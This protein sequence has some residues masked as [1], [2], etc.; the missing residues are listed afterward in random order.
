MGFTNVSRLAG[1]IIAYDRTLNEK[2]PE[3]ESMFRGSNFV[4]DGRL[5]RTITEDNF[6]QCV[7]CGAE[8][9]LVSNCLN[10][11]CHKRMV[12][13]EKCRTKYHGTCSVACKQRVLNGG[14]LPSIQARLLQEEQ[15]GMSVPEQHVESNDRVFESLDAYTQCHSSPPPSIYREMEFNTR[16]YLA[17]GAHM[18]SG[19][20]QGRLLTQL[21]SMTRRGRVLEI[22]TFTGY[23]TACLWEGAANAGKAIGQDTV[24]TRTDG[25]FVL[26][27]ERD[28]R[29]V[30]LAVAH[31]QAM[32][33]H[34]VGEQ[35]A[36]A[37]CAIRSNGKDGE[38]QPV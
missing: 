3:E 8:T 1:G 33:Q 14:K 7:T 21:A 22:G 18:V 29:A 20:M 2:A 26:S 16:Q 12:Q 15:Q 5:G 13:C 11:N 32:G 10:D 28:Q 6:G 4:F 23:A 17:S 34:G 37:I 30:N 27:L 19:E 38:L 31:L 35:G 9:N 36:E 25:P 24:G